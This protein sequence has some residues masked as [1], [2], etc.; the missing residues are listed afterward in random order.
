MKLGETDIV[1]I[2]CQPDQKTL[3]L[4]EISMKKTI[5]LIF[6]LMIFLTACG[7]QQ[8]ATQQPTE[9]F[10]KIRHAEIT[11]RDYGTIKLELDEGHQDR[12]SVV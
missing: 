6:A 9:P 1:L 4:Q 7:G 5:V 12:K 11:V 3:C 8:I 10:Q 2:D